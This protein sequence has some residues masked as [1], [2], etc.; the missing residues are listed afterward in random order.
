MELNTEVQR[1]AFA[2]A[3]VQRALDAGLEIIAITN[4]NS[5]AYIDLIRQAAQAR[6][7]RS[8][9]DTALTILP[10]VEVGTDSGRDG[11]HLL[12]IFDQ[13]VPVE[14][15]EEFLLAIGLRSDC[16]FDIHGHPTYSDLSVPQ[17]LDK[18]EEY[19]G[20][21]IAPHVFGDNGLLRSQE[22]MVRLRN[23]TN[24]RLLAVDFKKRFQD[25]TGWQ[26]H[27]VTNQHQD[28]AFRRPRPIACL[29]SSDARSLD[30][31]GAWYT[32]IK[33]ETLTLEG[34]RQAFLDPESRLRDDEPALPSTRLLRLQVEDGF[35]DGLDQTLN[36]ALNCLIGGRGAGKSATI[37]VIRH[38]F[39]LS[40]HPQQEEEMSEL[41]R[42]VFPA[43]AKATLQVAVGDDR[44][45]VERVG[46]QDP[47][48]Y[49]DEETRPLDI[50]PAQLLPSDERL[51]VY[52]QK[53]VLAIAF[54]PGTQ[55]KLIDRSIRE[56][57]ARRE[58]EERRLLTQLEHNRQDIVHLHRQLDLVADQLAELPRIRLEL[59][60]LMRAGIAERLA[61]RR[62]YDREQVLWQSTAER[63]DDL[64]RVLEEARRDATIELGFLADDQ[65]AGLPNAADLQAVRD[66][67]AQLQGTVQENLAR[68]LAA[69]SRVEGQVAER[70]AAWQAEFEAYEIEY[71]E[72]LRKI[73]GEAEAP[74]S[75]DRL[76]ELERRKSQL[77]QIQ[78]EAERY[79]RQLDDLCRHRQQLLADLDEN[80]RQQY[81]VR[82]WQ[83]EHLSQRLVP[84]I[85][86]RVE[87]AA[88]AAHFRDHLRRL[89]TGSG[90]RGTDYE[91]VTTH[92]Q[93]SLRRFLTDL[94]RA[95]EDL[96]H[97]CQTYDLTE[98]AARKFVEHLDPE[99]RLELDSFRIPDTV[100]I[101]LNIGT[102]EL[103]DYR[104]LEH[105]SVGQRC[106]AILTIILLEGKG[107]LLID[108]PEDDLDNR[109]IY[110]EIVQLL[111]RERGHR[112]ILV[113]THNANI[114]VAGDAELITAL[115]AARRGAELRCQ[116]LA[117]GFIDD[118]AVKEQVETILEGGRAAFE[119]RR[120]KYGF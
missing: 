8:E 94:E 9:C 2:E 116:V 30:E 101:E 26:R 46:F 98:T 24:P 51:E 111:R 91:K 75:P 115:T 58:E 60:N 48:A 13:D 63:L 67:L 23:F 62:Q 73:Q 53:E 117:S 89:L 79:Q 72:L 4:H 10:G 107:P 97:M 57:L 90:L 80:R 64:R 96:D 21:A 11:V 59:E 65:L 36:P 42:H 108:Q 95:E 77:E 50:I 110:D 25:L 93:F 76:M 37:Q 56:P 55:M 106:T 6:T 44:Y 86:V 43:A 20:L 66:L 120:L 71:R 12:A 92:P 49:R 82:R 14:Y 83:A 52:G 3:Y 119:L 103:P 29:N 27:V 114:P 100:R 28:P 74:F 41:I 5:T 22:G 1:R 35:L 118:P 113:A 7:E 45:R 87:H 70:K 69:V 68:Q 31:I 102:D 85:R 47:K 18:I 61:T 81:Q 19:G 17:M 112:Q 34:L 38:L 15:V 105:L 78:R 99:R 32:W 39:D 88:D 104:P 109:F 33:L 16:R 84:T 40:P 54:E